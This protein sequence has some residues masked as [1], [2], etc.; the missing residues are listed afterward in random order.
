MNGLSLENI[1]RLKEAGLEL[2]EFSDG[3][4][5]ISKPYG[6]KGNFLPNARKRV[7]LNR[8]FGDKK[9][10]PMMHLRFNNDIGQIEIWDYVPGPGPGDFVK[11]FS[12]S[13]EMTEFILNYYFQ[14]NPD[15]Q[16][17]IE[18]DSD[19][20]N[21]INVKEI[22][23]IFE[24]MISYL[25]NEFG[26]E[27]IDLHKVNFNKILLDDWRKKEFIQEF[28]EIKTQH[29]ML[30]SEAFYLKRKRHDKREIEAEDLHR[31]AHILTEL[32]IRLTEKK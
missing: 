10:C 31:M 3:E 2:K 29:G 11:E 24:K 5:F 32:S 28:T 16:A 12:S 7:E 9:D 4:L 15:F 26:E 22:K 8:H 13:N 25:G 17:K 14:P 21:A 6:T 30:S 18:D 1:A 20:R 19:H 27:D 23:T